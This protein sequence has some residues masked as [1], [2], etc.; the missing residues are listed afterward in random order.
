MYGSPIELHRPQTWKILN[1]IG[2]DNPIDPWL[3]IVDFNA[4]L[5]SDDKQGSNPDR[6]PSFQF[7]HLLS[8]FN[9]T[10][11]DPKGPLLT[12]NNN[13]ASPK[14]IQERID[15]GIVNSSWTDLFP[16][17]LLT[18]LGFFGSDHRALELV[19]SSTIT[20]TPGRPDKRFLFENDF[21]FK[22]RISRLEKDLELARSC[23]HLDDRTIGNIKDLQSRLDALLYK[24][25][26]YWKQRARTQWLAQGIDR[27]LSEI[28]KSF[29]DEAFSFEETEKAFFQLP[30][31]KAPGLDGFNSN[32]Y[33]ANW[34]LVKKDVL[35]TVLS[36]LN[37]DGDIAPFNTTLVTLIPK[38][39]QPTSVTEFRPISLCNI[40]YKIISKS[41][42]NRLK[43]VLNNLISSNQSDFL[44]GRLI[45][46]NIII[47]QE[48]VHSIKLK[49][50]GKK[51]WMAVKLDM[52]KAFDRVEWPFILA[53]LRKFNFPSRFIHLIS[54]CISTA[55]FQFNVNG[56]VSGHV[57]PSRGIRQGDPLSPT[58][59]CSMPRD[60]LPSSSSRKE[61]GLLPA[62]KLPGKHQ[63]YPISF[64]LMIASSFI[65]V[66]T[67]FEKY[68]GLPQHIGRTKKQVLHY[69]H[70][71]V[72][73]HL[74]NWKH[75]VFS[76]GGKEILLESVIQAIP[77]Y[78]MACFRLTVATCHSLESIM[79]NFLWAETHRQSWQKL[80]KSKKDGGLGFCSLVHFNQALLAKQAW[81]ILKHPNSTMSKILAVSIF[82]G[83][84][85]LHKGLI[86]K[87]GNGQ[88]T[89]TSLDRWIPGFCQVTP[90]NPVPDKTFLL[91]PHPRLGGKNSGTLKSH[92]RNRALR[93]QVQDRTHAI[94]NLAQSFLAD[95]QFS[96][97]APKLHTPSPRLPQSQPVASP[98]IGGGNVAILEAKSLHTSLHWCIEEN[99]PVHVVETDCKAINDALNCPKED[100]SCFGDFISQ[101]KE[102][103]S[104]LPAAFVS[105]INRSANTFI[106]K[107]ANWASGLD[108][109][110]I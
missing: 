68:L 63:P 6:G 78:S 37:G 51:G 22:K 40:I 69:L 64:S 2:K 106:D 36:F 38:V 20:S 28:D 54:A 66:R 1:K 53:I 8:S 25:E 89:S 21:Q 98:Y 70:D 42:A 102:A 16:D 74:N 44:P 50:K 109:V 41:I 58:F 82:W 99:F 39:K 7:R 46:D 77:T 24:E 107:L 34:S 61:V 65:P 105:H 92:L 86:T 60:S 83:K 18:H 23:S 91:L 30:L 35:T 56:K 3:V 55:T 80:C 93:R 67:S 94:V 72:W 47:A 17:A 90:L 85:L 108:E 103:L 9:L 12:W 81:H 19:T 5:S 26:T 104:H 52:A 32:F 75:K 79:A 31:D 73:G 100:L 13:V 96:T 95:Y 49:S 43:L 84:E 33:K 71:K 97:S 110:A 4:F 101:I 48:V 87:I 14:N 10:P 59:S 29:L 15:W 11:L 57:T 27:F 88:N 45:S 62:S 76:K